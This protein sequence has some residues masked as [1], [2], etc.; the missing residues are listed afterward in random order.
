MRKFLKLLPVILLSG[1][2]VYSEK[3]DCTPGK[4]VGCLALHQVDARV[5]EKT[6]PFQVEEEKAK[7]TLSS[8]S[9]LFSSSSP[10]PLSSSSGLTGR[11]MDSPFHGNDNKGNEN[12][13]EGSGKDKEKRYLPIALIQ[14]TDSI[15]RLPEES[16]KVWIA[17]YEDTRGHFHEASV[18]HMVVKPGKWVRR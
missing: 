17:P 9:P 2:S 15:I 1:C 10:S 7:H 11:S 13:N 12:G 6:L 14:Q 5:D 4:G 3:F 16:L 18:V 8:P